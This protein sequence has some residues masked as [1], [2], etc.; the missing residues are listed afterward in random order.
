M[1]NV[2]WNTCLG[3][4]TVSILSLIALVGS[5]F[6]YLAYMGIVKVGLMIVLIITA[7]T[8]FGGIAFMIGGLILYSIG[9]VVDKNISISGR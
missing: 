5:L 2:M 9:N 4:L 8:L 3:T 1:K 7:A 6:S